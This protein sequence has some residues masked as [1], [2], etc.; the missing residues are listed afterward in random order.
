MYIYIYI[1]T[2]GAIYSHS[3]YIYVCMCIYICMYVCMCV[4]MYVC[5]YVCMH[6]CMDVCMDV[7]MHQRVIGYGP[8]D[9]RDCDA[10]ATTMI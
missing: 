2:A 8:A 5:M 3:T 10:D 1:C 6:V 7:C 4:C 9:G